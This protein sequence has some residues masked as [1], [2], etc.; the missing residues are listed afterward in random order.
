MTSRDPG[1]VV[2]VPTSQLMLAILGLARQRPAAVP[3]TS[4][5]SRGVR[6]LQYAGVGTLA[7]QSSWRVAIPADDPQAA[8]A[9]R[10][11]QRGA[12]R[13]QAGIQ[14]AALLTALTQY[15]GERRAWCLERAVE[16]AHGRRS[17]RSNRAREIVGFRG[18]LRLLQIADI[19]VE[20]IDDGEKRSWAGNVFATWTQ[21]SRRSATFTL[22]ATF[23]AELCKYSAKVPAFALFDL[24]RPDGWTNPHGYGPS[25]AAL[26]RI[27]LAAF[28]KAKRHQLGGTDTHHARAGRLRQLVEL[29]GL[30][31]TRIEVR[32]SA[33]R[34]WLRVQTML[35]RLYASIGLGLDAMP[36]TDVLRPLET[37]ITLAHPWPEHGSQYIAPT[38]VRPPPRPRKQRRKRITTHT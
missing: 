37:M 3:T 1:P 20:W 19:Y 35:R 29:A 4:V 16:L 25:V 30:D 15:S 34:W 32:R 38:Q 28:F 22:D 8:E 5:D 11:I 9:S 2:A 17:A 14:L 23:L 31:I 26:A 36:G 18:W 7:G 24:H 12:E 33:R 6:W 10:A 27:R 21:H 13:P